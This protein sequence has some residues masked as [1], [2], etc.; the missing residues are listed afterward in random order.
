M[1]GLGFFD[2]MIVAVFLGLGVGSVI[3]ARR[4]MRWGEVATPQ[5]EARW[6]RIARRRG[7]TV[8]SDVVAILALAGRKQYVGLRLGLGVGAL[9]VGVC[10]GGFL[11][12]GGD[13]GP[14]NLSFLVVLSAA[15]I[16]FF[17]SAAISL[18]IAYSRMRRER[19]GDDGQQK[20]HRLWD[21][22]SPLAI[23][24]PF[25]LLF[26]NL[27]MTIIVALRLSPDLTSDS[28]ARAF[29]LS[30]MWSVLVTPAIL[31]VLALATVAVIW[32]FGALPLLAFSRDVDE[33]KR[34]D[35]AW[36]KAAIWQIVTTFSLVAFMLD[37][38]QFAV[39][40]LGSYPVSTLYEARMEGWY[41]LY[42]GVMALI[43][44]TLLVLIRTRRIVPVVSIKP[45]PDSAAM[46][47]S[48]AS[49]S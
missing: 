39:L 41:L 18:L 45:T 20:P 21:Y 11:L 44:L 35:Y 28:L 7:L 10:T 16:V 17:P 32:R 3:V 40:A 43:P 15:T 12:F 14:T 8:P 36:R 26:A 33:R 13:P 30:G 5:E 42:L 23:A 9:L 27:S 47:E 6:E 48:S 2:L 19:G 22:C 37:A 38:G 46:Q 1:D 25:L 4:I 49:P 34:V 24:L 29:A 31:L